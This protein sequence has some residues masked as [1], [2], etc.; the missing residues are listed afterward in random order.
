RLRGQ[1]VPAVQRDDARADGQDRGGGVRG[2]VRHAHRHRGADVRRR[3]AD[4]NLLRL[5]RGSGGGAGRQRLRL[6]RG[7]RAVRRGQPPLLPPV[8]QR[9]A[10]PVEQDRGGG[11]GLD[12]ATGSFTDVLPGTAFYSFV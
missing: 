11:G 4:T 3:A 10:R 2:A 7:Q 8:Q 5:H 6:R 1:H 12:P 9:H